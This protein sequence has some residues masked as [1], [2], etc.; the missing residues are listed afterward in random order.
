MNTSLIRDWKFDVWYRGATKIVEPV[1]I[2]ENEGAITVNMSNKDLIQVFEKDGKCCVLIN[3]ELVYC[4]NS[5]PSESILELMYRSSL[6][7]RKY[8]FL[9]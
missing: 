5:K 3:K 7:K 4:R 9:Q 2:S 1:D 8:K 6:T